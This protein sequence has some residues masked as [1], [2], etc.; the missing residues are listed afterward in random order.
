MFVCEMCVNGHAK[1]SSARATVA[2]LWHATKYSTIK[3]VSKKIYCSRWSANIAVAFELPNWMFLFCSA[4]FLI[5]LLGV[6]IY[7]CVSVLAA[8][9]FI[10]VEGGI[11]SLDMARML[12]PNVMYMYI[13]CMYVYMCICV[14]HVIAVYV[15]CHFIR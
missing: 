6:C 9:K 3:F 12:V 10:C 14:I 1:V 8:Q 4:I 15:A 11:N 7:T 13:I 2:T 5:L